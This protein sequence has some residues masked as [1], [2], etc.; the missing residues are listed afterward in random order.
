MSRF[1]TRD[2][3]VVS[4]SKRMGL[5]VLSVAA[6]MSTPG[7]AVAGHVGRRALLA[8]EGIVMDPIGTTQRTNQLLRTYRRVGQAVALYR[9]L[10]EISDYEST[11]SSSSS[12]QQNGGADDTPSS[13]ETALAFGYL[14]HKAFE[15]ATEKSYPKHPAMPCRPGF[16]E[17]KVDGKLVCVRTRK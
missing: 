11:A 6:P 3:T 13:V 5:V 16:V 7:R 10:L 4:Q 8:V 15:F 17:K 9:S 2:E 1:R 12:Y 14:G